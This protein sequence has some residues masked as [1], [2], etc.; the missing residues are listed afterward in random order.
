LNENAREIG[1]LTKRTFN[2]CCAA[3]GDEIWF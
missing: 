3:M 1:Q 2:T